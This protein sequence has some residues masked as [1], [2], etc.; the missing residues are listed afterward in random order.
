MEEESDNLEAL[1]K[2]ILENIPAPDVE[3]DAPL[4]ML[5]NTL[6]YDDYVGRIV[7]GRVIRGT[8]H[9]GETITL[10]DEEGERDVYK[11]QVLCQSSIKTIHLYKKKQK[12]KIILKIY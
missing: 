9:N 5:V 10:M 3:V 6:D 1:F 4:Q 12:D 2:V 11:R 7:V 8:I